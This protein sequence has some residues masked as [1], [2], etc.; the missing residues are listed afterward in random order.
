MASLS[1]EPVFELDPGEAPLLVSL[2]HAG[3][4]VLPDLVADW[5]EEAQ[6]LPD[7]DWRVNELYAF[8]RQLG[9]GMLQARLSR[10]VIDVNRPPDD[11]PL[12]QDKHYTEL[13]PTRMFTGRPIYREGKVPDTAEVARRRERYWQPYHDALERELTRLQA[14]HGYVILWEGHSIKSELPWLFEEKLPDLNLGTA[15]GTSCAPGLRQALCAV[16]ATQKE[17]SYVADGRFKGGYITRHY[18]RPEQGCHA[19]QLEISWSCYLRKEAPPYRMDEK[20]AAYL[21][22]VLEKLLSIAM[23]WKPS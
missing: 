21:Q 17:F 2:P 20:R 4:A 15:D 19:I 22:A 16:L 10:Y 8:V 5:T 3:T 12:Y 7:T 18:G 9:V 14:R 1:V 6:T 11:L 23:A 13:C